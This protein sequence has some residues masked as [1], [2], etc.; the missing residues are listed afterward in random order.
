MALLQD[1]EEEVADVFGQGHEVLIL[2][3]SSNIAQK[4][5][6]YE[7]KGHKGHHE[8]TYLYHL[9]F[10][11]LFCVVGAEVLEVVAAIG[12]HLGDEDEEDYC[13]VDRYSK[14]V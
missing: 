14:G 12:R 10:F 4:I 5:P 6:H 1:V 9:E 3:Y 7:Q 11:P 8:Q 2:T 13:S